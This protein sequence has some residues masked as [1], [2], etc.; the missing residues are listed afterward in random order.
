MTRLRDPGPVLDAMSVIAWRMPVL[1]RAMVE[2]NASTSREIARMVAEKQSA[3]ALGMIG[4]QQAFFRA[5]LSGSVDSARV[6]AEM[7]SAA[8]AP[9]LKTLRGNARR[10]S[11][12]RR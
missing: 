3:F 10:L 2:P 12:R 6:A 5:W 7:A 4:A 8:E 9:A 11:R 1:A